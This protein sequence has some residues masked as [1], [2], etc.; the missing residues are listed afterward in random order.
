VAAKRITIAVDGPASSGKGTVA[1]G[2][3]RALGYQYVDTGSMYRSVALVAKER[4]IA[5]QDE[6]ALVRLAT[7]LEFHF[8]WDGD[9]LRV[10]V[11]DRDVTAAI[12]RDEIGKGASDVSALPGVR[13]ALLGLQ[14]DLGKKGGVVMDGR[15]I[16][17]VVLPDSELKVFLDADLDERA[18]R[19]H[20][21]LLRRGEV[22]SYAKVRDAMAARDKQDRERPVAPLRAAPDAE[23]VDSSTLTIREVVDAVLELA[24]ARGA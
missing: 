16:G 1:R 10:M 19:R 18:R 14:R 17:T 22:T 8:Q 3:A 9:V 4:G 7:T 6:P 13:A 12:R 11:G 23:H 5:W 20:D 24:K 21:E 15:D 2:V